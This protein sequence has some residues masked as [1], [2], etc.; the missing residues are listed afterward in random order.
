MRDLAVNM[1][2]VYNFFED[3]ICW[4]CSKY[5]NHIFKKSK[6]AVCLRTFL[7]ELKVFE[8]V[9]LKIFNFSGG[10]K[11]SFFGKFGVLSFL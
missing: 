11:C 1:T 5:V 8:K 7:E 10:K 4:S 2:T 9:F 3:L 6:A